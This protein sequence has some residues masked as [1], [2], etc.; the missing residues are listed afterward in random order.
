MKPLHLRGNEPLAVAPDGPALRV[1]KSGS[2]PD[3]MAEESPRG[4]KPPARRERSAPHPA[5]RFFEGRRG[6]SDWRVRGA[7]DRPGRYPE[8]VG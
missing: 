7:I 6:V 4:S 5:A 1:S 8:E 2:R 3:P